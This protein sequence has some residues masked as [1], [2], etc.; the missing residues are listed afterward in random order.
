MHQNPAISVRPICTIR[1]NLGLF[2]P[3]T[4]PTAYSRFNRR[5]DFHGKCDQSNVS[6]D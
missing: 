1:F 2:H 5:A 6:I 3:T 4:E